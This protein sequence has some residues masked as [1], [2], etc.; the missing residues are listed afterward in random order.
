MYDQSH[1]TSLFVSHKTEGCI[2]M[3][4]NTENEKENEQERK[5]GNPGSKSR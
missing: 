4:I 2:I 1:S 5:K 3:N